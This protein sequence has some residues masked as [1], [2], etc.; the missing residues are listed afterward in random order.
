[1]PLDGRDQDLNFLKL[2]TQQSQVYPNACCRWQ[3]WCF[4][5]MLVEQ[6]STNSGKTGNF[7]IVQRVRASYLANQQ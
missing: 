4:K 1:M 7:S 3:A 6:V 2:P 5:R